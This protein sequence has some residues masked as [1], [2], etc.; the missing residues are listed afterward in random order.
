MLGERVLACPYACRHE[1]EQGR[2]T[3]DNVTKKTKKK[4]DVVWFWLLVGAK[5]RVDCCPRENLLTLIGV[6]SDAAV[7]KYIC[8][9]V[10]GVLRRG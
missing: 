4:L 7:A 2:K 10:I 1:A 3:F 9:R 6:A 5:V 8:H